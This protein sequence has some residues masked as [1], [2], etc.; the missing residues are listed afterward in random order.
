MSPPPPTWGRHIVF[1][2]VII[3]VGVVVCVI[4]CEYDNFWGVLNF[5]F[6][7]EPYFDHIKVSVE[8]EN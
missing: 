1:G 8:F 2:S 7:L 4:P 6:K 5:T 3:V